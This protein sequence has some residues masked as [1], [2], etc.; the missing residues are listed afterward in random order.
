MI[1]L[2]SH[3]VWLL[4]C[5]FCY[6]NNQ[7]KKYNEIRTSRNDLQM[8]VTFFDDFCKIWAISVMDIDFGLKDAILQ[9]E[10]HQPKR[11]VSQKK[12]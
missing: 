4:G 5:T 9:L 11:T 7:V 8:Q 10:V 2:N 6:L 3:M 1:I 12:R